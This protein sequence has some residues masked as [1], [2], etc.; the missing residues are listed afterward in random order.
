MRKRVFALLLIA[1]V[2]AA[3]L[4]ACKPPKRDLNEE[5]QNSITRRF[6]AYQERISGA[7]YAV[8]RGKVIFDEGSGEANGKL[9]NSSDIAYGAASLTKQFTA[10]CI[11]QLCEAKKLDINDKLGKYFPE[12][13]YGDMITLEQLLCQ[14]SGIPDYSVDSDESKVWVYCDGDTGPGAV[15]SSRNTS[16]Q[17]REIIRGLFFSQ[18]LLFEPGGRFD[19]S[20]SNFA[21][22]A[23]I[24]ELVSGMGYHEYVRKHIFEPLGMESSAFIDDNDFDKDM[25]AETDQSEFTG[26][27]YSFK[28]VEFGC[29]DILTTPRDLYKWYKGLTAEQVVSGASYKKMTECRSKD[30]ELGYGYG[31]MISDAS[32]SKVVYHYGFIPSYYSAVFYIPEYDYFQATLSNHFDGYPHSVAAYMA[33]FFGDAIGLELEGIG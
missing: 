25:L 13:K 2:L 24:V 15:I 20:D 8:Y 22:L 23:E 27:Y 16:E 26:D 14:R 4:C 28:G 10:A 33:A 31:L 32:E 30:D 9:G 3:A 7:T 29:G 18:R 5:Q 19:Y 21:L 1:A 12:Y 11:M 17:N 6:S